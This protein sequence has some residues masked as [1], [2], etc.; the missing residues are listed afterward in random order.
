MKLFELAYTLKALEQQKMGFF[1]KD[2]KI[3]H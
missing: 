1:R 2:K 3:C